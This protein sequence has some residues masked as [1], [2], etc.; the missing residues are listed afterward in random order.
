MKSTTQAVLLTLTG[1]VLLR[2]AMGDVYLRY[3]N[4]WMRWPLVACGVILILLSIGHLWGPGAQ[5]E[6]DGDCEDED[7]VEQHAH[8]SSAAW[9]LFLPSIV[10]FLVA[11]PALGAYLAERNTS[12]V[13]EPTAGERKAALTPLP[14]TDP[15]PV[16]V[17]EF[18]VRARYDQGLTLVGRS[19]EMVGFVSLDGD[20][21]WYVTRFGINCCAADATPTRVR[22]I[23]A[24]APPRDQWVRVVGVWVEGSGTKGVPAI[25]VSEVEHVQAPRVEYE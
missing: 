16:S 22:A 3:V 11:P 23:G 24:E 5:S 7:E 17:T 10:V 2:L 13:A 6:E 20:G 19:V 21:N 14:A 25:D 18:F 4:T 9:L 8:V 1:A 12:L 15:A